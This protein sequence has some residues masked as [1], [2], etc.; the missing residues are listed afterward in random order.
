MKPFFNIVSVLLLA[1][2]LCSAQLFIQNG[3]T[4]K[5]T[6]GAVVTLLDI[7]LVNNGTFQQ[8]PGDGKVLFMGTG[9]STV[10][11]AASAPL[12]FDTLE[13]AKTGSGKVT[14]Q[15]TSAVN[16]AI[17]FTTGL[18]DLGGWNILL[19]PA[20]RLSGE[21][22]SSH[23]I[24]LATG[25]GIFIT[26]TLNA[27]VAVNPGNLGAIITSASNLGATTVIRRHN[28]QL[29]N[30]GS[31]VTT[32]QRQYL[33]APAN[34]TNLNATLRFRYLESELNGMTES[35]LQLYKSQSPYIVT[36]N[37]GYT[38]RDAAGNYVEKT[39]IS[40]FSLWSLSSSGVPLP[41]TLVRFDAACNNNAVLNSWVTAEEQNMR[42]FEVQRS[43]QHS[44]WKTIGIVQATGNSSTP[45]EYSFTD[46]DP[47][48]V[49]TLYRIAIQDVDGKIAYSDIR[50]VQC[51]SR[52]NEVSI[53]PNP[54]QDD[55]N[56]AMDVAEDASLN[57]RV[58]DS[59]GAL[60]R[61]LK[62]KLVKGANQM[63]VG[64]NGLASGIY[65][66]VLQWGNGLQ[67]TVKIVKQ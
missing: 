23:S 20:A 51:G 9:N 60:V 2:A 67:Q 57:M 30:S 7:D 44:D 45:Q 33:I 64:M 24:D 43:T 19:A 22:E 41:V 25:G 62:N 38:T 27:P 61:E 16:S 65:Q 14:M 42:S 37:E 11:G 34:N 63:Q 26:T 54:V 50:K 40:D 55:L 29:T 1:P 46:P 12:S 59:K 4:V 58:F 48:S 49:V 47:A 52:L 56:I 18:L 15:R 32:I 8:L 17:K 36:T 10:S 53:W 5:T 3:A 66:L 28:A 39:G 21:S 35:D 6:N 13:V 31:P